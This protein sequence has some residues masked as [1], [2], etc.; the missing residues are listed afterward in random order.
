MRKPTA[1][2]EPGSG[3]RTGGRGKGVP[4]PQDCGKPKEQASHDTNDSCL[5]FLI[6]LLL[7][8]LS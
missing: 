3:R 8:D 7:N 6:R 2:A 4:H 1:L 5:P